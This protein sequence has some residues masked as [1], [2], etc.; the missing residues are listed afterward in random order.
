MFSTSIAE[1]FNTPDYVK[2]RDIVS[3]SGLDSTLKI[4]NN[5][6]VFGNNSAEVPYFKNI[7]DVKKELEDRKVKLL[8]EFNDLYDKIIISNEPIIYR[9]KYNSISQTIEQIE[10]MIDEIDSYFVSVNEQKLSNPIKNIEQEIDSNKATCK[11]VIDSTNDNVHIPKSAINKLV[12]VHNLGVKLEQK[13]KEAKEAS[14]VNYIIWDKPLKAE[15]VEN[16]AIVVTK[17]T[18]S[19]TKKLTSAKKAVIKKAT[20]HLMLEKLS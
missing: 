17:R 4:K 16:E 5:K 9:N 18:A 12:S 13:L 20:K 8:L 7:T 2:F 14:E 6:V 1:R 15:V 10:V 19:T 11:F 3:K